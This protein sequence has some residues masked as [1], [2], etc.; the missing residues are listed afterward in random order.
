MLF[1][2]SAPRLARLRGAKPVPVGRDSVS[3]DNI[4][5]VDLG[6]IIG[7]WF[8]RMY[9]CYAT[10]EYKDGNLPVKSFH[11]EWLQEV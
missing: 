7:E 4:F 6:I 8:V 5:G 9:R 10:M 1:R 2:H 3:R 11:D